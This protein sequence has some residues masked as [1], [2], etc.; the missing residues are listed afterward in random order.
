MILASVNEMSIDKL[1]EMAER[2][3]DVAIPIVPIVSTS[4]GDD[5]I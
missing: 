3:M 4:T 5:G 2:I 1:A